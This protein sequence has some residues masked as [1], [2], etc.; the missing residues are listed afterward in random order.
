MP[1][2]LQVAQRT[3]IGA[4]SRN[5]DCIAVEHQRDHWCLVLSDGAG[6]HSGGALAAQ[7]VVARVL[8]GFRSRPPVES[9]DLAELLLDAHDAVIAGQRQ[10]ALSGAASAMHA[11]VVVLVIDTSRGVALWG[12]VGDS[13]LYQ[14]R[15]GRLNVVTR[16]DSVLQW[17][18]DSGLV[19]A[20]RAQEIPH[21]GVLLAALG[22]AEEAAPHVSEPFE[23]QRSDAFLL[24]SD[25]WWGGLDPETIS[26]L[27][28]DAVT[29]E[30][31]LDTMIAL[32]LQRA[33]PRQ[34]NYSAIACWIGES[35]RA[36]QARSAAESASESAIE[37]AA[38]SAAERETC[39][40]RSRLEQPQPV[41]S[42]PPRK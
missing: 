13:R 8:A 34:D 24:C 39:P 40:P 31:W 42:C 5:E 41:R 26:K 2:A 28:T 4:R 35:L 7:L 14:W 23:L 10:M 16:D 37:P 29:P 32:T 30:E 1:F 33:D 27:L 11:T 38:E 22:S 15:E 20:A 25:G 36:G 19:D 3:C 6:G 21:R 12:H 9:G 18:L 17:V